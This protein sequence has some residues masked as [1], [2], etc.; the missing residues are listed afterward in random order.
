MGGVNSITAHIMA[1]GMT[2]A[3]IKVVLFIKI[4]LVVATLVA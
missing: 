4:T 3:L 1:N 2:D